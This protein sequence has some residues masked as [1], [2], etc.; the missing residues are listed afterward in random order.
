MRSHIIRS[1]VR[2]PA[3]GAAT[4]DRP[5]IG[6]L[7]H[8]AVEGHPITVVLGAAGSGKTTAVS[9]YV[10]SSA[11]DC[12]W[13]TVDVAERSPSRLVAYLGAAVESVAPDLASRIDEFLADGLAP[14]DCA[15][16][17]AE[18]LPAGSALV[19]DDVHTVETRTAVIALLSALATGLAED[20]RLL[21]VTRRLE[22]LD[23]SREVLRRRVATVTDADL[24][25]T[26]D[27]IAAVLARVG[28]TA[29]PS[30][31]ARTSG[32]WAAGVAF[33]T[34]GGDVPRDRRDPFFSYL[35]SEVLGGVPPALRRLLIASAVVELVTPHG[36]DAAAR[37]IGEPE[38]RFDRLVAQA[39]PGTREQEGFRYHPRFRE[40]LL[41]RLGDEI[42]VQAPMVRVMCAQS[43]LD[44]GHPEEAADLLFSAGAIDEVIPVVRRAA[45]SL[46]RRGDWDKLITW[47]SAIGEERIA[48]DGT[49]RGIQVRAVLMSRRQE[50]VAPVVDRM[51]AT[52]EFARHLD[53]DPD[54][55]AWA[56]WALH[57]AGDLG[58]L[59]RLARP[60]DRSP[61]CRSVRYILESLGGA[62]PPPEWPSGA[63]DNVQPL[64]IA[65]Q[66]AEYY[67]GRFSRLEHLS[68][69]AATK[70]PVTATLGR[71]F[72][73]AALT[74]Q[75]HLARARRELSEAAPRVRSSRFVEFWQM[76]DGMLTFEE[77][78][79]EGG[80]M[81]I[82]QARE[83][84]RRHGYRLADRAV[85][86][87]IEGKMLVR[88]GALPD[89]VE[90][91]DGT[92]WWCA[93][94]GVP[95][96]AE[97]AETWRA[98]ALLGLND[99][100]LAVARGLEGAIA[101]M[102]SAER[103]L[104]LVPALVFLAEAR[105]RAGDDDDHDRLLDRAFDAALHLG[106]LTSLVT[107]VDVFPD[108]VARRLE[109]SDE[110]A[111][112]IWRRVAAARAGSPQGPPDHPVLTVRT[113]G[114]AGL[115]SE[116]G[117]VVVSERA[118]ALAAAVTAA[119]PA[120]LARA[121]AIDGLIESS[122]DPSGY[123]RQLVRRLRAALPAGLELRTDDGIIRWHPAGVVASDDESLIASVVRSRREGDPHR[124]ELLGA[125]VRLGEQGMFL[126]ASDAPFAR[127]RR[128]EV[129]AHL[130]EARRE[131]AEHHLVSG[132]AFDAE[133]IARTAVDADP[134]AEDAWVVLFR[135]SG[136]ARGSS[137]IA[138]LLGE[139]EERL[140]EIGLRPSPAVHDLC[141]RLRRRL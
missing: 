33:E 92:L 25:L 13:L 64:H 88:S 93:H 104:E 111:A 16:L 1:K 134:Y 87:A 4:V 75:G 137:A 23:L 71:I 47:C 11:R 7:L 2:V 90:I 61:R 69:A 139:Y 66:S 28:S 27:E 119:G 112:G 54:V 89:A 8:D 109:S 98:A 100:A 60:A 125:A 108:V 59:L 36:L 42:P 20:A 55:A 122:R 43:L 72:M 65:L 81:L 79:R 84:S 116:R 96:M 126:P 107:A 12:A 57:G 29:D 131:L 39:L 73:I 103:H 48:R 138:P 124:V 85:F 129:A 68:A 37:A 41:S 67:R 10:R 83:T 51:R 14:L 44:D 80:I 19:I 99:D 114:A 5:R 130:A 91:L 40:F 141:E 6:E 17:L 53:R 46:M 18:G 127:A 120:G 15:A 133:R 76:V 110:A 24:A 32:G 62:D 123:L 45:A 49:L 97:W 9:Q 58:E 117:T 31:V 101:G 38:G 26:P 86:P 78:D 106:T 132:R 105:W 128:A 113:I 82:R 118:V 22:H 50:D 95:C 102:R 136:T 3:T 34:L 121:D 70:G 63:Y 140:A 30:A 52:G 35:G 77:G 94:H 56:V 74:A 135:S 21:L 115:A